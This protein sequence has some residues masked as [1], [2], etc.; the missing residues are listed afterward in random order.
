MMAICTADGKPAHIDKPLR[1][2]WR[3]RCS[4]NSRPVLGVVSERDTH[5]ITLPERH[6][7]AFPRMTLHHNR[8]PPRPISGAPD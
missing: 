3:R 4:S 6:H 8:T 2:A 1:T 5:D 7:I